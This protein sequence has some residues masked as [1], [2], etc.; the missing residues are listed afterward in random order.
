[1]QTRST[2]IKRSIQAL[3]NHCSSF[4]C[5]CLVSEVFG[6]YVRCEMK[7]MNENSVSAAAACRGS[8]WSVLGGNKPA[9]SRLCYIMYYFLSFSE[10]NGQ[11][12]IWWMWCF[13]KQTL[14][15]QTHTHTDLQMHTHA[16][17]SAYTMSV[18]ISQ[19]STSHTLQLILVMAIFSAPTSTHLQSPS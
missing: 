18:L 12:H 10:M 17:N 11:K 1:M 16:P 4:L 5:L 3:S 8:W 9:G 15:T 6:K 19:S 2:R 14:K 13:R 7:G